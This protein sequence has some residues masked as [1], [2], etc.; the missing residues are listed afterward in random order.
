MAHIHLVRHGK[1]AAGFGSHKDPGLDD[2]GRQQAEA[3]AAMLDAR[4]GTQRPILFSS[5]L[6]RAVETAEPLAARWQCE[7]AIED[8]VAEIPSPTD[9][10]AERAQWLQRAMQGS[11]SELAQASQNWRQALVDALLAQP[12]DCIIFSHFVAINAAVGA[13]TQD[14]RMRIFAPD[15]CSVTTLDNSNGQLSVEALGVTAE[16]HIN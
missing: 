8:R 4:H 11:W 12:S 5:P 10:L 15:N 7:V 2:L 9:D 6:A 3:V 14:D 13:A 16:T 1:A